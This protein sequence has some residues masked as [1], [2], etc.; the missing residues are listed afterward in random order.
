MAGPAR[1]QEER[2][3]MNEMPGNLSQQ[4]YAKGAR[5]LYRAGG[6]PD[7]IRRVTGMFVLGNDGRPLGFVL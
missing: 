5:R 2:E 6:S 3:T 7:E 4:E 1:A